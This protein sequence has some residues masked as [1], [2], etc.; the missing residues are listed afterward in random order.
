MVDPAEGPTRRTV[1]ADCR[2]SS[3]RQTSRRAEDSDGS[4]PIHCLRKSQR[5]VCLIEPECRLQVLVKI[6]EALTPFV[7]SVV[8]WIVALWCIG[9]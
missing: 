8:W 3:R 4:V 6:W 7:A 5:R 2:L 1:E 9:S